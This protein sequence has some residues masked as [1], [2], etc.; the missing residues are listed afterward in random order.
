MTEHLRREVRL[1]WIRVADLV[2]SDVFRFEDPPSGSLSGWRRCVGIHWDTNGLTIRSQPE[3]APWDGETVSYAV[4]D[5]AALVEVQTPGGVVPLPGRR[6]AEIV[7][8]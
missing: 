2:P 6:H 7:V 8:S 3:A 1:A 4:A 5:L